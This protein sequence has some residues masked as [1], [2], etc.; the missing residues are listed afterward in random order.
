MDVSCKV[1]RQPLP[2]ENGNEFNNSTMTLL[3]NTSSTFGVILFS[4]FRPHLHKG[5][6]CLKM[7]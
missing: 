5:Y 6:A 3:E 4:A 1:D 7:C 2:I